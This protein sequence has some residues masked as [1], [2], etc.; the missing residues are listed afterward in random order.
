[1]SL[2]NSLGGSSE[3][4]PQ[5]PFDH[6]QVG[7]P[8]HHHDLALAF[9]VEF[10]EAAFQDRRFA[11]VASDDARTHFDARRLVAVIVTVELQAA[12]AADQGPVETFRGP[13]IEVVDGRAE[14][15]ET[16]RATR[17]QKCRR[18]YFAR[19]FF[20]LYPFEHWDDG[21][22]IGIAEN[23]ANEIKEFGRFGRR[24]LDDREHERVWMVDEI[25]VIVFPLAD[26]RSIPTDA[27]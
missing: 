4:R 6:R 11:S 25:D 14:V 20:Q 3:K 12:F 16:S 21:R 18:G 9:D 26:E 27:M 5:G 7:A 15:V 22:Q 24:H 13:F 23:V 17:D 8:R 2:D 10:P 19:E 1:M